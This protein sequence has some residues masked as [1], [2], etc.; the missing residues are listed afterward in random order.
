VIAIILMV[1]VLHRY[2]RTVPSVAKPV[3]G[4]ISWITFQP[5]VH[6]VLDGKPRDRNRARVCNVHD[7]IY[8]R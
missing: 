7:E 2:G 3:D 1:L 5:S 8:V 4:V 6:F